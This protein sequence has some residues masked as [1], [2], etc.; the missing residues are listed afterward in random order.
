MKITL[1]K[2]LIPLL[3]V[4]ISITATQA[5]D[6]TVSL[7]WD[8]NE[9]AK[10]NPENSLH[11]VL[12]V[13]M[14]KGCGASITRDNLYKIPYYTYRITADFIAIDQVRLKGIKTQSSLSQ[15]LHPY[16][17]NNFEIKTT[18]TTERGKRYIHIKV[19]PIRK[20]G[21]TL[22]LLT[23]FTVD[24][25]TKRYINAAANLK[26]KKDQ[27]YNSVLESGNFY[28]LSIVSDGVYKIDK[29]FLIAGG[30]DLSTLRMSKFKLYGNGG[31][32]LPEVISDQRYDDLQENAIYAI[33]NNGNDL[34][35]D[36]DYFLWYGT[37]PTKFNYVK[38][39]QSYDA[40][41]H[42][43]DVAAYYFIS[44]DSPTNGKRMASTPANQGLSTDAIVS[45]YE[46]IIYHESNEENHIQSGRK[47]WGD[48]MQITTFKNFNYAINNVAITEQ[49]G[50]RAIVTARTLTRFPA[51]MTLRLGDSLIRNV[52]FTTVKGNYDG[53]HASSPTV[54][55]RSVGIQNGNLTLRYDFNKTLNEAA[56]WIDYHV[57]TVPRK[58]IDNGEQ[59]I[60]RNNRKTETG[61]LQY[62]IEQLNTQSF[63][64]NITD[65]AN[66][67]RQITYDNGTF[68]SYKI[69]NIG[70]DTKPNFVLASY[71]N[72]RIP[73]FI[74][75]IKNQNLHAI[76]DIDYLMVTS[77]ELEEQTN[78]LADFHRAN[79]LVVEV[80]ITPEVYNEFSSGAQD[81]TAI[82]DLSK[83]IYDRGMLSGAERTFKHLLLFGDA[84]Y[85][86]KNVEE[87]NTNV[88]P[89]YQ[90]YESNEPTIS[91]C[92]DDY[93]AILDDNEGYW[94]L[95]SPPQGDEGLDLS[96]G[97]LP[98]S[99]AA[100]AKIIVDKIIHYH[101][102]SSRGNWMQTI[103]FVGD[104]EDNN[105]HV[106]PS[107]EMTKAIALQSPEYNVN[108]IWLDAYEQVSFGSGNKYPKVNEDITKVIGTQGTLIFNYVG[109]GGENGMAHERVVT[110]PEI[111]SWSNYDKLAFY[112]T[113]SCELAKIDNLDIESPGELMLFDPDGGAIGLLATTRV[114]FI[115]A[116]TELNTLLVNNNLLKQADGQ[117]L[118]LGES[119]RNMRNRDDNEE[120][121]KRCFILLADPAMRLL[122]PSERV[123]TTF[124]NDIPIGLFT[125]TNSLQY[126]TLKALDLITIEGEVRDRSNTILS[127]FNGTVYPTFFD[128]PGTYK[129]LVNDPESNPLEFQEQNRVIYRG[130]VTATNGKFKFQFVVP[131]DIAYNVAPGKLSYYAK[132]GL[133]HG[134]G[135][136]ISYLVGGTSDNVLD[137]TEFDQL[138]LYMDDE[139]WVFGGSTDPTPLLL[140]KMI[141]S[142]GIN[143]IGS[144][145][146][147]EMVATIDAGTDAER[148]IIV[149]DYFKPELNS[150]QA[151]SIEY[152]FEEL[153]PGRHTL[154]LKVWDVYNNSKDAYT[155]FEVAE[156]EEIELANVL[157][158]PNPFSTNTA[159]HF[160]HNKAGQYLTAN[161]IISTVS[162]K[163]VKSITQDLPN[164][165]A[166][167][168][169]I[170]WNGRDDYGDPIGRGVYIYT[171]K[172]RAEDGSTYSKTE[173]LYIVN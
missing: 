119:Y 107:E 172:V 118:P 86:Y 58:L 128:K 163:A 51:G 87:N 168:A 152:P 5:Q 127:N 103:T 71:S 160:D 27:T 149:N 101:T 6:K 83:L 77:P 48:K 80:V 18:E 47:W 88:V 91:Y 41:G 72:A 78:R 74:G 136:E 161:L 45:T 145:I 138:E 94:G 44:W 64:W 1:S 90:S 22:E 17:T 54:M 104:D 20:N 69:A 144:G 140:A 106:V 60:I 102:E 109:H 110:R 143:T 146:G 159:F 31:H 59:Q 2:N 7:Q 56:A 57:L 113:A 8:I 28:K 50:V 121:N 15:K 26:K 68:S 23:N 38:S 148:I 117:L 167:S 96:V 124:I 166:H 29:S 40:T 12:N 39:T 116:N 173:K 84:S 11:E 61:N 135:A 34:M 70:A 97:R 123:T 42:D 92:S 98:A 46:H 170:L 142:S 164:A 85:D 37:G 55:T 115:G 65:P 112:I 171:L 108:K 62:N 105:R 81:V 133:V 30:A 120:L 53:R 99:N 82:R 129:T 155:E 147:R 158:Y 125:D 153:A 10:V 75:K 122:S 165:P 114:V 150:Y 137:D 36:G 19:T 9:N 13:A 95:I 134:G 3:L 25:T 126:D 100:E 35:D 73:G 14:C 24:I 79:G 139:S 151:G 156:N 49:V 66:S 32:M 43:F 4:V 16:I 162:G 132:D 89:I 76:K 157:N 93:Y 130:A 169:D 154:S 52:N 21:N 67:T 63:I 111:L 141:D 33:D 131:K